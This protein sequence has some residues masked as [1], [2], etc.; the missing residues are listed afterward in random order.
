MMPSVTKVNALPLRPAFRPVCGGYEA[1]H[2][3]GAVIAPRPLSDGEGPHAH[4]HGP[5]SRSRD[6][7]TAT[8]ASRGSPLPQ[9]ASHSWSRSPPSPIGRSNPTFGPAMNPFQRHAHMQDHLPHQNLCLRPWRRAE[10]CPPTGSGDE[11]V[12]RRGVVPLWCISVHRPRS[13]AG[14]IGPQIPESAPSAPK[15][16]C[17]NLSDVSR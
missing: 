9:V 8:S 2:A 14:L 4:H 10:P 6:I 16:S 3:D 1:P 15:K 11:A 13:H 17:P 12:G 5:S 7:S